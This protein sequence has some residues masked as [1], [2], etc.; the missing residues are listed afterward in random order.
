ML[1]RGRWTSGKTVES[2]LQEVLKGQKDTLKEHVG[3]C[4]Q[5][6]PTMIEDP[7]TGAGREKWVVFTG[8]DKWWPAPREARNSYATR[9]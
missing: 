4:N 2:Y 3:R 7:T 9:P 5:R 6:Y 1:R 8:N